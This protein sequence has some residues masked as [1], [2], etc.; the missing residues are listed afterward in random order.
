LDADNDGE[1]HIVDHFLKITKLGQPANTAAAGS[2][3]VRGIAIEYLGTRAHLMR[4]DAA[5]SPHPG[6]TISE[7]YELDEIAWLDA[8]V[9]LLQGRAV[10]ELDFV[11]LEEY[12]S[13][14]ANRQRRQVERQLAEFLVHV[15]K[16]VHLP[17]HR[18]RRWKGTIIEQR[19]A[20]AASASRGALRNHAEFALPMA[21]AEAVE[22]T[23][24]ETGLSAEDLAARPPLTLDELLRL[25]FVD[26]PR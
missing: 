12:L 20:L 16:W 15:L 11:H 10:D 14:N 2:A 18:S 13:D 9:A 26:D 8:M 1:L 23:L 19:Q 17:E 6:S 21:Y 22:R 5:M 7:L 3:I 4:S 25:E 24:A